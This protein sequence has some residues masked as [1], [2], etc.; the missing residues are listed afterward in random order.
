MFYGCT[1]T[2]AAEQGLGS[3]LAVGTFTFLRCLGTDMFEMVQG[4][5]LFVVSS[6]AA[7]GLF[8]LALLLRRRIA[9][10]VPAFAGAALLALLAFAFGFFLLFGFSWCESERLI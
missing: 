6:I 10:R 7:I 3:N 4:W 1:A 8:V 5:V 9:V 2:A